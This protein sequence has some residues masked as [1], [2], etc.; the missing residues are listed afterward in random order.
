MR[1]HLE[2]TKYAGT[3]VNSLTKKDVYPSIFF[4][5]GYEELEFK[6][7][8]F[9]AFKHYKEILSWRYGDFM[10]LSPEEDRHVH[11]V[12]VRCEE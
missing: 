5:E 1:K 11:L 3:I 12:D 6:G 10:K 9:P 8:S 4:T 7:C 2:N